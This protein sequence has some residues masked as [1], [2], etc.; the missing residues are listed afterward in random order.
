MELWK[1][2]MVFQECLMAFQRVSVSFSCVQEVSKGFQVC[3]RGSQEHSM[4]F[5]ERSSGFK[6]VSEVVQGISRG[7][8]RVLGCSYGLQGALGAFQGGQGSSSEFRSVLEDPRR[9]QASQLRSKCAQG[10]FRNVPWGLKDVSVDFRD[11]SWCST[12]FQEHSR[13]FR[14]G[15][16]SFRGFQRV[17]GVFQRCST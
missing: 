9:F 2:F 6:E 7:I 17:S 12:G 5:Q 8:R 13:E 4:G 16:V 15:Q 14:G 3:F 1:H 11:I 10:S